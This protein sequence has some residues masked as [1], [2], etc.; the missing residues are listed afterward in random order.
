[1]PKPAKAGS[2]EAQ[3]PD[4]APPNAKWMRLMLGAYFC[5]G[6]GYVISA[7]FIVAI[8]ETLP[9]LQGKGPWVWV[10][11][12]LAAIPSTFVWDRVA[13]VT[14]VFEALVLAY[15]LQIISILMA[16]FIDGY[17]ANMISAVLFGGT[18]AGIVNLTLSIAGRQFPANPSKAMARMTL[19][20]GVSQI[21]A[22]ALAGLI[23]ERTGT[24]RGSLYLAA[25]IMV[26][27][28]FM[29]WALKNKARCKAWT[30]LLANTKP[31]RLTCRP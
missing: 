27:G 13:R 18:F 22:P 9:E 28:V 2:D 6:F 25:A 12:G 4:V 17:W 31:L 20:Y 21:A 5:A 10:V 19:S 24:Y 30:H 1:M 3:V 14:G 26:A 23:A 29:V 16:A 11:V 15:I 8:A 7:T